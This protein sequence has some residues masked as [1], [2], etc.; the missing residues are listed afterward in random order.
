MVERLIDWTFCKILVQTFS[1]N[2]V[3]ESF[4]REDASYDFVKQK[5]GKLVVDRS[6]HF[7]AQGSEPTLLI[8]ND[9]C[10]LQFVWLWQVLSPVLVTMDYAN[11]GSGKA[12]LRALGKFELISSAIGIKNPQQVPA[13]SLHSSFKALRESLHV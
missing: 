6:K 4:H 10:C 9:T 7:T 11:D 1:L 8:A 3:A 12:G 2:R 13:A 5:T